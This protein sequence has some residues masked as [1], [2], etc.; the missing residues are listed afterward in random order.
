M[1]N[2]KSV[3]EIAGV[4]IIED[5][6][7]A[8]GSQDRDGYIVGSCCYSLM[9]V[10]SLHLVKAIA[11]GEGGVI[12]TNDQSVCRQLLCL[13]SHGINKSSDQFICTDAATSSS[14]PNPWYYEIQELG[15]HYRITDI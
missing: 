10:F 8:L 3:C 4:A 1:K 7:H 5:A 13:R 15:F 2:I 9:T 14:G 6:A 12:T 11:A